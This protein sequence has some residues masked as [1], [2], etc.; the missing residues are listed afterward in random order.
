MK[1]NQE[2]IRKIVFSKISKE[3]KFDKLCLLFNETYDYAFQ[4]G[5]S[6]YEN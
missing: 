5:L 6:M 2:Q 4:E 3:D 1:L